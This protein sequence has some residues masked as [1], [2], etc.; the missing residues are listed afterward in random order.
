MAIGNGFINSSHSLTV[1]LTEFIPLIAL[2]TNNSGIKLNPPLRRS[3]NCYIGEF[4][5]TTL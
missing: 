5:G 1:D 3:Y 4:F 2:K